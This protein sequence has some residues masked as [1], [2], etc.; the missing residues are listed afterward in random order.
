[1]E[2]EEVEAVAMAVKEIVEEE[3]VMKRKVL[4]FSQI[5]MI[6]IQTKRFPNLP[7]QLQ[8]QVKLFRRHFLK[9]VLMTLIPS[10]KKKKRFANFR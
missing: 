7:H 10:M 6:Q 4:T 2:E 8:D 1:M 9:V 3:E 5:L